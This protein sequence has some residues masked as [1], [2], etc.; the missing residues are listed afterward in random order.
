[1]GQYHQLDMI[2]D[3]LIDWHW[4]NKSYQTLE[5]YSRYFTTKKCTLNRKNKQ[6]KSSRYLV[7]GRASAW[8][9]ASSKLILIL[10][11][12]NLTLESRGKSQSNVPLSKGPHL[13]E[14]GTHFKYHRFASK[15]NHG[16]KCKTY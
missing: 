10:E 12:T 6:I 16:D 3:E 7:A 13:G 2:L 1:M 8:P 14:F 4:M 9:L 15:S 5:G 11:V